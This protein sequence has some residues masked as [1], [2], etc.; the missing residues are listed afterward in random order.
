MRALKYLVVGVAVLGLLVVTSNVLASPNPV[1]RTDF[2]PVEAHGYGNL[3]DPGGPRAMGNNCSDIVDLTT[4]PGGNTV[5]PYSVAGFTDDFDEDLSGTCPAPCG[6]YG[7][8]LDGILMFQVSIAGSWTIS[9]CDDGNDNSLQLR[10]DGACPGDNC[11][12]QDDDMCGGSC[13]PPYQATMTV[14][15][16]V[17]VQYYLILDFG[18]G[19]LVFMGPCG[20]DSDCDDG[21]FCN[22]VETCDL[23]T[24]M[25]VPGDTHFNGMTTVCDLWQ[26]CDEVGD[27]CVDPDPCIAYQNYTQSGYYASSSFGTWEADDVFLD[28]AGRNLESYEL[29][30]IC[31]DDPANT[32]NMETQLYGFYMGCDADAFPCSTDADCVLHGGDELCVAYYDVGDPIPYTQCSFGPLA[33]GS[34][35]YPTVTCYPSDAV[36]LPDMFWLGYNATAAASTGFLI[37]GPATIGFSDDVWAEW[38]GAAWGLWWFGGWPANPFASFEA[39]VCVTPI[40]RCCLPGGGCA[41]N[42]EDEC[43]AAGGSWTLSTFSAPVACAD[44]DGDGVFTFCDGD[45]CPDDANPLQENC[46]GDT[47]GDACELDWADQDDDGDGTCNGIDGCPDDPDKIDPGVC[48]CGTP[49]TDSDGDGAADCIDPCPYDEFKFIPGT[50]LGQA[51]G[52][53][54]CGN[55]DTDTD[56]DGYADCIDE[57]PGVDNDA[58]PGCADAIPTVS[59]WG[60]VI[61][62]LLLLAAGKVYF[63]RRATC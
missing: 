49:D 13:A 25:C 3:E 12:A 27:V 9:A 62:A 37:N 16:A 19:N 17:G 44:P 47:E 59:E 21:E 11:V 23:G 40:G 1:V 2:E 20:D 22:G 31:R 8:S 14:D 10:S 26:S 57:C 55:P 48:G 46:D 33:C 51:P 29:L 56:G 63:G 61:L 58:F 39:S 24:N 54:G 32:F 43:I 30:V 15:L 42:M 34:G 6:W 5:V 36:V 60:L 35:T 45:N 50:G 52:Q 4:L 7:D 41:D 53:C 38:D 28:G 18:I